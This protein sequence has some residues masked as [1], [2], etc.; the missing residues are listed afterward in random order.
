MP[1]H[2]VS[3]SVDPDAELQ[4]VALERLNDLNTAVWI[5]DID[6]SRVAW[7]NKAALAIWNAENLD[8]L[9]A[10]DMSED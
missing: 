7:A 2:P 6:F 8:E 9:R 5:F 10:R 3:Y 4:K 1:L